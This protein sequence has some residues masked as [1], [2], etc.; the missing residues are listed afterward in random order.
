[1]TSTRVRRRV[2]LAFV[3][4]GLGGL[5][6]SFAIAPVPSISAQEAGFTPTERSALSRGRIVIRRRSERHDGAN[7]FGGTSFQAIDRSPDQVWRAVRD[8]DHFRDMLPRVESIHVVARGERHTIARFEHAYGLI[9]AAYHL[10]LTY[11]DSRRDL[12]F[13]VDETRPNDVRAATGFLEVR[14]WPGRRDRSLVTWGIMAALD[15]GIVEGMLRPRLHEWMLRVPQ[16]MRS[17]LHR[18][19]PETLVAGGAARGG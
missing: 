14:A 17:F 18:H 6:A 19:E 2:A 11:D 12:T 4:L 15:D 3:A 10:R 8:S 7:Y 16:T 13:R 5:A 9:S 1:M